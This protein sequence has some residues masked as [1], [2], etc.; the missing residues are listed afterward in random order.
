MKDDSSG[1]F[2][3][4]LLV[5]TMAWIAPCPAAEPQRH[6]VIVSVDGLGADVLRKG[7]PC[8]AALREIRRLA[9][10]GVYSARV[11]GIFP[12]ITVPSHATIVTGRA[13]A[14]HGVVDNGAPGKPYGWYMDRSDIRGDTLWDAA[15]KAGISVA[16][17]TWPLTYG[18]HVDQLI[19]ENLS[20]ESNVAELIRQGSTPGL[21]ESLREATGSVALLPFSA[22]ESGTPLDAMTSRFADEVVRRYRPGLLLVH[23]LDFDHRQH[24]AGPGSPEACDALARIDSH[25]GSLVAAYRKAGIVENTTFFILSDHGFLPVRREVNVA[26]ILAGAGWSDASAGG[27]APHDAFDIRLAGGSV[28]FYP[29]FPDSKPLAAPFAARL[30]A[31]IASRYSGIARWIGPEKLQAFGASPQAAFALCAVPGNSFAYDP[32]KKDALAIATPSVKGSHGYCPDEKSMDAVFIANG[33]LVGRR[34]R[35]PELGI[36]DIGPTIADLIGVS[37]QG[38]SGLSRAAL[39]RGAAPRR[40]PSP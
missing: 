11:R 31:S 2:P 32:A 5:A 37:L 13:P 39:V 33:A 36:A 7:H 3:A 27:R 34:G 1:R 38:A 6:S 28:V 10:G 18:A 12:T 22:R 21:F 16:I 25:V 9:D 30:R 14:S 20:S 29:K 15:R 8:N 24:Y 4:A 40:K 26:A 23:F 17:V 35:I 19:P